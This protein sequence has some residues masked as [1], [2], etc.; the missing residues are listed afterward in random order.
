[1]R[2]VRVWSGD[3]PSY[4]Y[5]DGGEIRLLAGAP[6][7]TRR[8][9]GGRV[10]LDGAE[11]LAPCEPSKVLAVGLNYRDHAVEF[12]QP[13]P[14]E[15]ILFMKPATAVVGPD[16]RILLPPQSA[17]VDYEAELALVVGRVARKL[18]L[19]EAAGCVF[20][21]TCANDVT[22]RDLQRKDGQWTRAKSFDT[23][24]PIGPWIV[25]DLNPRDLE[26]ACRVNGVTRQRS[27]T[28]NL[29]FGPL[30]LL[31]FISSVMTLMPGDVIMTGTPSG[32]G[33]LAPGDV[34]EVEIEGIGTL[35]NA[36]E[37]P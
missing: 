33:P 10:A 36:A 37:A 21:Y 1:V 30:E 18:K 27:R 9:T 24:C 4:G 20:G 14:D 23:F 29:A 2:Y 16:A 5:V 11:L 17:Q 26:I 6:W 32:V 13:L 22:A 15:P 3:R 8:Q 31:C 12:G 19:S 25:D 35:R 28:G 7:E 34:V